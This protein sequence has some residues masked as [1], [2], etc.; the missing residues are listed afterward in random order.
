[1]CIVM[2]WFTGYFMMWF[3]L[4]LSISSTLRA[5]PRSS[6]TLKLNMLPRTMAGGLGL[7]VFL[8]AASPCL[9]LPQSPFPLVTTAGVQVCRRESP[10]VSDLP[11]SHSLQAA[12]SCL[13]LHV[14]TLIST[15]TLPVAWVCPRQPLPSPPPLDLKDLNSV[16]PSDG[17]KD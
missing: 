14:H 11:R 10:G 12:S 13:A 16:L 17:F 5:Q 3:L 4:N 9:R 6:A 2:R 7:T 8:W 1:M 15:Q